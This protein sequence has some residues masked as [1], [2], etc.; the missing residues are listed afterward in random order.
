MKN[1]FVADARVNRAMKRVP[2]ADFLP[3]DLKYLA[4]RDGPLPIGEEQTIS[5][6]SLVA[7]MTEALHLDEN[8]RVLEVGT[9]CG[10]QTAVL[11]ELAREVFTVEI[12]SKLSQ[13]AQET[14]K[15][16]GYANVRFKIGDGTEGWK[17]MAPFDAVIV[18]A[19]PP[20]IPQ[21][22]LDQLKEGGTLVIPV[23]PSEETQQLLSVKKNLKGVETQSLVPVRFV[24]ISHE[25]SP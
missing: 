17:E 25:V 20:D 22:L 21:A 4:E 2:R 19:A 12:R 24:P 5:Q 3:D 23:G 7:R 1:D 10:Y 16:L 18:T 8:S 11:A 13:T 6:P 9:G 14:L 15:K